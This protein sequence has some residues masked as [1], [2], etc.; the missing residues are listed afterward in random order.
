MMEI[1]LGIEADADVIARFN[2][3]MAWETERKELPEDTIN[4]GVRGLFAR[5]G[6]GFY[7]LASIDAEPVGCLMVTYE[8]SDWRNKTF[9]WIQSVYV[10]PDYRGRGLYKA[11][12]AEVKRRA[13]ED[14]GVCGFRLYV[15]K[16]NLKAQRVYEHL[17]MHE[18]PY[19]MFEEN[20]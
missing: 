3:A 9:W 14:G 11:L 15:E 20:I 2:R 19:L 18:A 16:E 17:G 4:A 10:L 5:P 12:Y 13:L 8:W 1:R 6:Q 7:L